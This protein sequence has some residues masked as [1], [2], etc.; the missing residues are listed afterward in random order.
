MN[1]ELQHYLFLADLF[2][3]PDTEFVGRV[4]NVQQLLDG[5]YPEAAETLRDFTEYTERATLLELEE[6][7]V[8][9]FDVQAVTTL[10]IGYVLFG[11]DYKRGAVLVNLNREHRE[12]DNPCF[13]ELADHLPNVLCLLPKLLDTELC[14]QLVDQ[15]VAPAVRKIIS[16]FDPNRISKKKKVYLRHH[17]TWIER[18]EDYGSFYQK[19]L[20]ALY[21]VMAEDFQVTEV[22]PSRP[23]AD[24]LKNIGT[25][26]EL[27]AE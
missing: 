24:F 4:K 21:T 9:S 16:E 22:A 5:R 8:R 1:I 25:E 23:S 18:S 6:L 27:E 20:I 10:D 11:D 3:Y 14:D 19:P 13:N 17:K 15:I 7:Y 2:R 26:I 12:V